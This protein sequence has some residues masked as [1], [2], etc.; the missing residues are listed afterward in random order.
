MISLQGENFKEE[1]ITV[2]T[3]NNNCQVID[4]EAGFIDSHLRERSEKE[5]P[6]R[7]EVD[8]LD[9]VKRIQT[10]AFARFR[11]SHISLWA[12]YRF[13]RSFQI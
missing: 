12:S 10:E 9:Y 11:Y 3:C 8:D 13:Y 6:A 5:I 7:T 2:L 4:N 1:V